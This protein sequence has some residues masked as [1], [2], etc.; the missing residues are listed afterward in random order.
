MLGLAPWTPIG[1]GPRQSWSQNILSAPN[2]KHGQFCDPFLVVPDASPWY[3]FDMHR[4]LMLGVALTLII[5]GRGQALTARSIALKHAGTGARFSGT[6]HTGR[7][8]DPRAMS[9]LSAALADA[10]CAPAP[11]FDPATISIAWELGQRAK[12]GELSVHSGYRTPAVNAAV[13]GVNDS[14]HL[15]AS[16]LDIGAPGGHFPALVEEARKLGRGGVGI[17]P[18]RGFVHLDSGPVRSWGDGAASVTSGIAGRGRGMNA[19]AARAEETRALLTDRGREM[20]RAASEWVRR[21]GGDVLAG[22]SPSAAA[23][24]PMRGRGR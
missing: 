11:P 8:A 12:L 15:R 10:G 24:S 6:W 7:A 9:E 5:P 21:P 23:R 16:A 17:Y 4:R 20:E 1:A 14:F 2:H 18:A 3:A 13:K 22:R 19:A